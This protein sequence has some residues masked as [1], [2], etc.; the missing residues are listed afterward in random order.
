MVTERTGMRVTRVDPV[1]SKQRV[2]ITI[3]EVSAPGGQNGL[4]GMALYPELFKGTGNDYVLGFRRSDYTNSSHGK[5][6]GTLQNSA[7]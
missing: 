5:V 6:S 3:D 2:V 4:L 1:S 7:I